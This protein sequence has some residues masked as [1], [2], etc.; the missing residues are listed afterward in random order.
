MS[1]TEAG[2]I[3]AAEN[4]IREHISGACRNCLI[5]QDGVR[6]PSID[7]CIPRIIV[8]HARQAADT[9]LDKI[10][11]PDCASMQP[12]L[13]AGPCDCS[14]FARALQEA[15]DTARDDFVVLLTQALVWLERGQPKSV[16]AIRER[17]VLIKKIRAQLAEEGDTSTDG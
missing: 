1:D 12:S 10:H 13:A 16:A 11:A 5:R 9:V 8:D 17:N 2:Q 15:A 3:E 14:G 6:S 4:T 7:W